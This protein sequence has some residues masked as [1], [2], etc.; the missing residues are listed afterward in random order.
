MINTSSSL[1]KQFYS[2]FISFGYF[3][4]LAYFLSK[5]LWITIHATNTDIN[6]SSIDW[7]GC[8]RPNQQLLK[9]I[10]FI[11]FYY[12]FFTIVFYLYL[13][14]RFPNP[15]NFNRIC[16]LNISS[17]SSLNDIWLIQFLLILMQLLL[18]IY[19]DCVHLK[20]IKL[21]LPQYH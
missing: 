17:I 7:T 6:F 11:L 12:I 18:W 20:N 16:C 1:I 15:R 13:S 10:F 9:N 8:L 14:Y 2:V 21:K 4:E 3:L 5:S 19:S